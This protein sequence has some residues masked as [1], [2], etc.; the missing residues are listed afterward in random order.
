MA[1][2]GEGNRFYE[3]SVALKSLLVCARRYIL[4]LDRIIPK[5]QG[6]QLALG[7]ESNT[8]HKSDIA[9]KELLV[10][11]GQCIPDS[12]CFIL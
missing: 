9:F 2:R 8:E 11:A 12:N 4:K 1:I 3:V 6:N 7:R 10:R 5:S